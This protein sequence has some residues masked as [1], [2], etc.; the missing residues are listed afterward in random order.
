M[1]YVSFCQFLCFIP[2]CVPQGI[3][4]LLPLPEDLHRAVDGL[5]LPAAGGHR[6]QLACLLHHTL[7]RRGFRRT[8]LHHLHLRGPGEADSPGGAL[9]G[10]QTQRPAEAHPVLASVSVL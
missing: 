9:S 3:W 5:L 1:L 4:P 10:Q 8:N 2:V 6:C 7:H